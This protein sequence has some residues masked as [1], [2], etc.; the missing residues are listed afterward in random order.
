MHDYTS[1]DASIIAAIS[2]GANT[3]GKLTALL[4]DEAESISVDTTKN[5]EYP[6]PPFRIVDRRLQALRKK[7][8]LRFDRRADGWALAE[9]K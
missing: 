6:Q 9:G 2:S 3:A 7:G 5:G 4:R 8:L 1:F